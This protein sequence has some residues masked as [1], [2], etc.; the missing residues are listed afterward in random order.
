VVTPEGQRHVFGHVGAGSFCGAATFLSRYFVCNPILFLRE[1]QALGRLGVTP[2]VWADPRAPVT[3][4]YDM[5]INQLIEDARGAARHGSC[6]VGFGETIERNLSR[7]FTLTVADLAGRSRLLDRLAAIRQRYVPARLA[8]LGIHDP[9][10]TYRDLMRSDSLLE[11]FAADAARFLEAVEIRDGATIC[12]AQD[13]IFEGAQGLLL[14]QDRGYFPHV[15]RSNTGLRNVLI[16][17][18]EMGIVHLDVTYV[19]R[20]YLTRHGAGPMPNETD[21]PPYAGIADPTNIP[22]PYQGSLRFGLL[23]LD[24]LAGSMATDVGD[25]AGTGISIGTT[26]AVTCLDQLNGQPARYMADAVAQ[27]TSIDA[28]LQR[29]AAATHTVGLYAVAGSSRQAVHRYR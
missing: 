11:A 18:E 20:A 4:P 9:G 17:A 1:H 25:A 19:T 2:A 27:E 22:H 24:L 28:F 8:R 16:L 5:L 14:D 3:T 6:G 23:D 29:A 13:V 10:T 15:T 12:A 21:G 26:L 7:E